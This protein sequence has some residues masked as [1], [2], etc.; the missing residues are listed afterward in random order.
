[1]TAQDEKW[2][3]VFEHLY[4]LRKSTQTM[5]FAAELKLIEEGFLHEGFDE[6]KRAKCVDLAL[7]AKCVDQVVDLLSRLEEQLATA[8]ALD[9][10]AH[11]RSS[12][13]SGS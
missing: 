4:A 7:G 8:R 9:Y 10:Q 6:G 5:N 12:G 11:K 3:S 2:E 13:A 1:M